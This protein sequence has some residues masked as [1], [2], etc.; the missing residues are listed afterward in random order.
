MGRDFNDVMC[1]D[2]VKQLPKREGVISA[3]PCKQGGLPA[4]G[5]IVGKAW[6]RLEGI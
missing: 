1:I 3:H 4:E 6:G 2:H 5:G